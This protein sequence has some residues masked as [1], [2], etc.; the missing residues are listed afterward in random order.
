MSEALSRGLH[1]LSRGLG[2]KVPSSSR[3]SCEKS[4][5]AGV[6]ADEATKVPVAR[7]THS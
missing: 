3:L 4:T 6:T 2:V 7:P 1:V 5:Q